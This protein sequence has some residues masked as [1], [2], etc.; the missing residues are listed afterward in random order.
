MCAIVSHHISF[1][2]ENGIEIE[3]HH[4]PAG[5]PFCADYA[6][7]APVLPLRARGGGAPGVAGGVC[8]GN[9]FCKRA[10]WG[11]APHIAVIGPANKKKPQ[12]KSRFV[13]NCQNGLCIFRG[14]KSALVTL[15][16]L[17]SVELN[18]I[19]VV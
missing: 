8:A 13:T 15:E 16:G 12:K 2:N 19:F 1:R 6:A 5:H 7:A 4:R 9:C 14:V 3:V 17:T 18:S 10:R 11:Y